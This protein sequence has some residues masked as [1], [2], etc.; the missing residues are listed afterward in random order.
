[1]LVPLKAERG[2]KSKSPM[3]SNC[4]KRWSKL[5]KLR[6]RW[7]YFWIRWCG[8]YKG[9]RRIWPS[10]FDASWCPEVMV[11]YSSVR[12]PWHRKENIPCFQSCF[13]SASLSYRH[14]VDH[15][16]YQ[17]QLCRHLC[18]NNG[19]KVNSIKLH[20]NKI[21][22]EVVK[23]ARTKLL[24]LSHLQLGGDTFNWLKPSIDS[25]IIML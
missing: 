20:R 6:Y 17:L 9:L 2:L 25:S 21:L 7:G 12:H 10:A 8:I 11:N 3:S 19:F 15:L 23:N 4:K 14:K 1:M 18:E 13:L 5:K 24:L 22:C 16:F